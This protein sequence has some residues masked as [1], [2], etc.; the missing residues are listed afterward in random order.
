VQRLERENAGF[1]CY[2]VPLLFEKGLEDSLRPVVLV[3]A[4]E[5]LQIERAL[6]RDGSTRDE[7]LRRMRAQMPLA[8]KVARADWVITNDCT[9][10]DLRE[11]ADA[12]VAELEHRF[13]PL[14]QPR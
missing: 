5:R 8:D 2:A 14:A 7:V 9:L 10:H 11:R 6:A 4:P 12:V 3:A 13:G 1:I